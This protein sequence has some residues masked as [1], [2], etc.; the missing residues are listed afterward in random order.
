MP[1]RKI[2]AGTDRDLPNPKFYLGA[3]CRLSPLGKA[4]HPLTS[5]ISGVVVGQSPTG[6]TIMLKA[7]GRK[8][9]LSLHV[10]YLELIESDSA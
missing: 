8:T 9:T 10:S 6:N 4:R 5:D 3:K 7:N 2:V 1:N